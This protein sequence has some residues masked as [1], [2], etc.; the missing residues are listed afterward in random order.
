MSL[1][2]PS[3]RSAGGNREAFD[4][5]TVL[6]TGGLGFIGSALAM[7]LK[8]AGAE[9]HTV[10][11]RPLESLG[12]GRHWRADL[13]DAHAVVQLVRAVRPHFVFHLAS[14]VM[15]APDLHHVLP[16]FQS[17][18]QTTVNLLSALAEVGCGRMIITGSL[19]EPENS[20]RMIPN[21]P[22]AA[23]KWAASDYARMFHAL[24]GF[25]AA[26]ARVFMVYG[27]GQQDET[28]LVPYVIRSVLRGEVPKITSGKH[29]I[30]W[31]FVEDVVCGLT[32][33]AAA[34]GVD[35]K[36]V[37]LGS[38]FVIATKEL[39]DEICMLMK[40]EIQPAYGALPDRPIEPLRVANTKESLR[41]IDWSPKIQLAEGLRRTIDWYGRHDVGNAGLRWS[42]L[43]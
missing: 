13:S 10:S 38:G 12:E 32:K 6:V 9:I 39:V 25:P 19:V 7:H 4:G 41:L 15:G 30:D 28:K 16:T 35:G 2:E 26:I 3:E 37:D 31:I 20:A 24:Y 36:S 11:R 42:K 14:H 8:Q 18:L 40:T 33:L 5:R 23:A 17:N 34:S 27:P 29:C 22:Y 43:E 1:T 21:S